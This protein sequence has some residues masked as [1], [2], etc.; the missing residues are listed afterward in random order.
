VS[1]VAELKRRNVF[2][3]AAIYLVVA[4]LLTQV[5]DTVFP[6]LGLPEWTVTLVI[7]L[8]LLGFPVA[9]LFAWAYELTPEGLK[10]ERKI[11]R[12]ESITPQTGRRLDRITFTVLLL[13]LA[14]FVVDKYLLAP[15]APVPAPAGEPVAEMA[16]PAPGHAAALPEAHTPV[17]VTA[18]AS[19]PHAHSIAVLPFVN[20]SEDPGNE[21]FSDGISD[22]LL[23]LLARI[24]ELRVISR[25]SAFSFKGQN[26]EIPEI[27][28]RLNVAH[29]LEGSVRR[30]G[31]RVRITAQLIE[32]GTD[33][34]LWTETYDRTLDDIFAI[35]DEIA[36]RVVDELRVTLLGEVPRVEET[37]PEAYTLFLEAQAA[38]GVYSAESLARAEELL[39]QSLEIDPGY[40][41]ARI[42]L[43]ATYIN[44][45]QTGARTYDEGFPQARRIAE[46]I[47]TAE[48]E[49]FRAHEVLA[50][51]AGTFDND[52]ALAAR[53]QE[54]ALALSPGA[55]ATLSNTSWL[56]VGL[57]RNSEATA[58]MER[59]LAL[60][61]LHP[62]TRAN[63]AMLYLVTGDHDAAF[64]MARQSLRLSPDTMMT[65]FVAGTVLLSRGE[66]D[67]S[68]AEFAREPNGE[69][70]GLGRIAA[71]STLG[72]EDAAG[73]AL[74]ELIAARPAYEAVYRAT[75]SAWRGQPD[76]AF[77]WLE[78]FAQSGVTLL[79]AHRAVAF[80]P[81]HDDARWSLFL[82]SI[83]RSPE[84]LASI[85]LA[86][87]LPR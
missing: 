41:Q 40:T 20:M 49:N 64:D 31:N 67:E 65:R 87:Q 53:H 32:A 23:N 71:Y 70:R 54:R 6:R 78:G 47:L 17:A 22:E 5:S 68:L 29:V 38:R 25:S 21:F 48:P 4:W 39:R 34:H 26:L 18:P 50:W 58:L 36:Q 79:H 62:Q 76:E 55:P 69:L 27:A 19:T 8:L 73:D 82:E 43:A 12:D 84:Q 37:D 77:G 24:P 3:V 16:L 61:P 56:L 1:L 14:Y 52:L 86:V 13:A 83:G 2:R 75:Y 63:L 80:E 57:G 60:D 81:L 46:D 85:R 33:S 66:V 42:T 30:A 9:V 11:D 59:A 35:Q 44:Q 45:A 51:I 7:V 28:R 15:G 72:Q 74:A 10:R